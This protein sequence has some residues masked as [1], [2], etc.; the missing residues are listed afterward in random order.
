M[1]VDKTYSDA[2]RE[3]IEEL[4]S[5]YSLGAL[6]EESDLR[7]F[8][9]LV[10]SGDAV[11]SA[12]LEEM[13]AA[14]SV[15]AMAAPQITPPASIRT[16]LL[17]KA[18]TRNISAGGG[19]PRI[20][21]MS[22]LQG[23]LKKRTRFFIGTGI[24]SGIL[25]CYLLALNIS[26]RSDLD[27]KTAQMSAL[28][29]YTDSI[30]TAADPNPKA[31]ANDTQVSDKEDPLMKKFFS[32][33]SDPDLKLITLA[34]TPAGAARQHLVYSPKQRM[35]YVV[36]D[37]PHA[38]DASKTYQ[39]SAKENFKAAVTLGSFKVDPAKNPQIYPFQMKLRS[40]EMFSI[41]SEPEHK[42]IFTGDIA[43]N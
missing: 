33:F 13:L 1:S 38:L 30:R 9:Q 42:V 4:A 20:D 7:E 5:A 40:P 31:E 25:L 35:I 19:A 32:T 14:A 8:E 39:L 27:N 6:T 43:K 23:S 16:A 18:M 34:S 17:E 41:T 24:L 12:S 26:T 3:H 28:S 2:E 21:E 11:L 10:E 37:D 36:C 15:L 29:K 22:M